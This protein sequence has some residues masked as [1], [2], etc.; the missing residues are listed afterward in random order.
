MIKSYCIMYIRPPELR[1]YVFGILRHYSVRN[2]IGR[3]CIRSAL[4][5][6]MLCQ[7]WSA[8]GPTSEETIHLMNYELGDCQNKKSVVLTHFFASSL[9]LVDACTAKLSAFGCCFL[10]HDKIDSFGA[11]LGP[12]ERIFRPYTPVSASC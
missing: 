6:V 4:Y 3:R 7:V 5:Q 2:L 9:K 12:K 8:A 1:H 11:L 10:G